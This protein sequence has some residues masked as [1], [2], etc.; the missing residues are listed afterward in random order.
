MQSIVEIFESMKPWVLKL[1]RTA[2]DI[3]IIPERP[4]DKGTARLILHLRQALG[5]VEL[6]LPFI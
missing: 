6:C 5:I 3:N 2:K 1:I 4:A